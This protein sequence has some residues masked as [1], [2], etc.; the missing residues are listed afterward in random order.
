MFASGTLEEVTVISDAQDRRL[1]AFRRLKRSKPAVDTILVEGIE[2]I[3]RLLSSAFTV[4]QILVQPSMQDEV[5][6]GLHMRQRQEHAD[7]TMMIC[8][9]SLMEDVTGVCVPSSRSKLAFALARRPANFGSVT[10]AIPEI[11]DRSVPLRL[12]VL[13]GLTDASNVGAILRVSAA[14]GAAGVICS[15]DCCDPLNPRAVRISLGHVFHVPIFRGS[16]APIMTEL[17][18]AGI[19]TAAAVVQDGA[20]YLDN[21]NGLSPR[22]ALVLGSEHFGVSNEVREV[23]DL[24]VKIRMAE[25]VDSFNVVTSAGVL[26]HGCVEREKR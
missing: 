20:K 13:D 23:C 24:H 6:Q 19:F 15:P 12:V 9:V 10:E 14:F 25:G 1:D 22:W 3:V 8:A 26:L 2:C 11:V 21:V 5:L 17:A 18:D 4:T 7:V 16:L